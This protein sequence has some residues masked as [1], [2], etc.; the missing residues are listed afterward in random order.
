VF[1]VTHR[2]HPII[3][4]LG[5]TSFTYVIDGIAS[6][7]E[8]ARAVAG[9][10]NVAIA[11][12]GTLLRQVIKLGLLD[13]LEL[14][15]VPVILGEGMRLLDSDIDIGPKQGIE[16][17][18]MRVISTPEATHVRY[19]VVGCAPL[20]LDYRVAADAARVAEAIKS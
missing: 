8:Q 4:R 5:G 20:G 9:G 16:L 10:K 1:V 12:G 6:A 3:E 15:I 18:P 2:P 17:E 19:K 7:I 11:G 13:E 14:H